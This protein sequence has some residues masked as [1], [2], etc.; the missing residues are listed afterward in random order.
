MSVDVIQSQQFIKDH[1][2]LNNNNNKMVTYP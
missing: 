2:N 1:K